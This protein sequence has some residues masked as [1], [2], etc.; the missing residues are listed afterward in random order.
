MASV[1]IRTT[2]V[3]DRL[4]AAPSCELDV[5]VRTARSWL[6]ALMSRPV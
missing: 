1:V 5:L 4:T 2:G 6:W 3:D